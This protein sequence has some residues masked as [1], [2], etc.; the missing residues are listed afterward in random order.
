M[1]NRIDAV[2]Y[3]GRDAAGRGDEAAYTWEQALERAAAVSQG[4]RAAGLGRKT[5]ALARGG[6][7]A[8]VAAG[9]GRVVAAAGPAVVNV[10]IRAEE[11]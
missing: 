8:P 10:V 1:C 6:R 4:L 9:E 7:P 2:A 5:R 3:V 11:E